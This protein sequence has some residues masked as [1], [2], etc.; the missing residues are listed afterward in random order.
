MRASAKMNAYCA[1][2]NGCLFRGCGN[3][4]DP[5]Q[6]LEAYSD[7][8]TRR[9]LSR[10]IFRGGLKLKNR[11]TKCVIAHRKRMDFGGK[12]AGV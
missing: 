1:F 9:Y 6:L 2:A 12:L 3:A 4:L 11:L 7:S 5:D 10:N 8:I